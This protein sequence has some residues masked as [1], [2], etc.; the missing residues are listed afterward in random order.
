MFKELN[1]IMEQTDNKTQ[2]D[3]KA[4][5]LKLQTKITELINLIGEMKTH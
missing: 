2:K 1:D 5:M 4:E 3:L